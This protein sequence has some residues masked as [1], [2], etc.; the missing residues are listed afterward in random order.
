[1]GATPPHKD[2]RQMKLKESKIFLIN[3]IQF[4]YSTQ[5]LKGEEL[6]DSLYPSESTCSRQFNFGVFWWSLSPV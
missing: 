6:D 3:T 4:Q 2:I 1:M 5:A